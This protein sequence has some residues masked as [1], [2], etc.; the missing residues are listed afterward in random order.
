MHKKL[1]QS[2]TFGK[3]QSYGA[4]SAFPLSMPVRLNGLS[5]LT[6]S[7]AMELMLLRV[8]EVTEGGSVPEIKVISTASLPI[9]IVAGE[10]VKGAKQNR[11]LNTSILIPAKASLVIPVSCTERGR[12]S[13]VSPDFKDSGNISSRDVR[14]A[15]SDS[16]RNSLNFGRG[17]RSDQGMV[18][19]RIEELHHKSNSHHS[20]HSRAMDDAFRAR[21]HDLEE[22]MRHF[23][24]VPG[25]T[26]VL[27]FHSGKVAGLDLLSQPAAY[28][29]LHDKLVK[30]Y[31]IDCLEGNKVRVDANLLQKTAL[32][33]LDS[34]AA[35]E[36]KRFKSP[37]LGN[38]HRISAPSLQGSTL[39]YEDEPI[40]T[41]CFSI[42][43]EEDSMAG[44]RQRR[45]L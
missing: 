35:G 15:A 26:G 11:I 22:A 34:A 23:S 31:V 13:Y 12:W 37:G 2:L 18:W 3:I 10:E 17:H 25:Q 21:Q 30:S 45:N 40:H 4:V 20:S 43:K 1:F 38:D 6:L 28:A 19:D 29:R 42:E 33:F 36:V 39:E 44:F 9:L 8:E 41:C 16:V 14:S 7:E 32:A 24:L 5:Y 27:F